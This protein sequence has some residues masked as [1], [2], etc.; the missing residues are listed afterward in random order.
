MTKDFYIIRDNEIIKTTE[1]QWTRFLNRRDMTEITHVAYDQI[2]GVDVMT[3]FDGMDDTQNP[4]APMI[5]ATNIYCGARN[6]ERHTYATR[7][8]AIAGHN[9]IVE[10]I[11]NA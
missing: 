2:N 5:W 7:E 6:G 8:D 4:D 10:E 11:K 1:K 3:A 9:K